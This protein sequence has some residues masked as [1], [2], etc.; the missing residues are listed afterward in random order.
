[1]YL[2]NCNTPAPGNAAAQQHR[3]N[4]SINLPQMGRQDAQFGTV[5]GGGAADTLL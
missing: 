4:S 1:M 5:F 3:E 2:G